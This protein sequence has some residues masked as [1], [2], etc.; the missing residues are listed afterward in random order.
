MQPFRKSGIS[1]IHSVRRS[2]VKDL[3]APRGEVELVSP[4]NVTPGEVWRYGLTFDYPH[5]MFVDSEGSLYIAD[6][7]G[8]NASKPPRRFVRA[9]GIL[10]P[11][12][13]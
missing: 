10:T 3:D 5:G 7:V 2:R 12:A 4:S 8:D 1:E 6:P 11:H 9:S 13:K